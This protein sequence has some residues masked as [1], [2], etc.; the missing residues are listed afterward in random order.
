MYKRQ[1]RQLSNVIIGIIIF[2]SEKF[3]EIQIAEFEFGYTN[4]IKLKIF[5]GKIRN[6][7]KFS[8]FFSS[9]V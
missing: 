3:K 9:F 6:L 7:T 8:I 1:L 5:I 2:I 4:K